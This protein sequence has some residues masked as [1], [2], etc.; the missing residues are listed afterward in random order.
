MPLYWLCDWTVK[1]KQSLTSLHAETTPSLNPPLAM[2]KRRM[3][4]KMEKRLR[5]CLIS[6]RMTWL[7]GGLRVS[8]SLT[9]MDQ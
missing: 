4:R 3:R 7:G 9:G 5:Q 2:R 6:R 1:R 8:P